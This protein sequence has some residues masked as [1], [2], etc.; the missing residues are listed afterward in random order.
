MSGFRAKRDK[1]GQ[2]QTYIHGAVAKQSLLPQLQPT[3]FQ[4][5]PHAPIQ[6][7]LQLAS[8]TKPVYNLIQISKLCQ[9]FTLEKKSFVH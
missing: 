8:A 1:H 3:S 2:P 5:S 6:S 4:V 9:L 7:S